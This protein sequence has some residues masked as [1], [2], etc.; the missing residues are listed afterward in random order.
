[1]LSPLIQI[2]L[3]RQKLAQMMGASFLLSSIEKENAWRLCE[4]S[5]RVIAEGLWSFG[6][7][8]WMFLEKELTPCHAGGD[9]G[10]V[11]IAIVVVQT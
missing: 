6:A 11:G 5:M 3:K 10:V 9:V 7:F 1:M 4:L 2:C 8:A